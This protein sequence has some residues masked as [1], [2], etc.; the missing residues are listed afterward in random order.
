[1]QKRIKEHNSFTHTQT[2]AVLEH[3]HETSHY[4]IWDEVKF[5]DWDPHKYTSRVKE[6]IHIK[7]HYD[8]GQR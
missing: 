4:L 8:K 2:S 7:L 3:A 5:I 6:A 1:M